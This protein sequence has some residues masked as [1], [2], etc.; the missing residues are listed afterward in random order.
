VANNNIQERLNGEFRD[1][2]K[3][4]RVLKNDG[5]PAIAGIQIYHN[6]IRPRMGLD[7]DTPA[8]SAGIKI[9]GDNK[10]LTIIQNAQVTTLDTEKICSAGDW[11]L[12]E[13]FKNRYP[14]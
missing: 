4:F 13:P 12:T 2:E 6:Y 3:V 9:T 11:N 7:G 5:S 1:R 8:S 10:W 14:W